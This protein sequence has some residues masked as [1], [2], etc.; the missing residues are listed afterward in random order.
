MLSLNLRPVR[1][2]GATM[3]LCLG[4]LLFMGCDGSGSKRASLYQR[5]T[6]TWTAERLEVGDFDFT[7]DLYYGPVRFD[8]RSDDGSRAYRVTGRRSDSTIVLA[9]G[10]I[11]LGGERQ[12]RMISGFESPSGGFRPVI[13]TYRFEASRAIF[14]LSA[15]RG[16]GSRAF[17][18]TLFPGRSWSGSRRVRLRLAPIE[19]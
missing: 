18:S 17:L 14:R 1:T 13:W 12:L 2:R 8:F 6:G 7:D 5:L 10:Q 15:N 9:E 11:D 19:E 3:L 16:N 4:A